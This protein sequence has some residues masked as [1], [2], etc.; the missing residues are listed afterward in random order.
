LI[1]IVKGVNSMTVNEEL[2]AYG[3]KRSNNFELDDV[4]DVDI[5]IFVYLLD[6]MVARIQ[7]GNRFFVDTNSEGISAAIIVERKRVIM[8]R[9]L[10]NT[11]TRDAVSASVFYGGMDFGHTCPGWQDILD[12]GIVGLRERA[13]RYGKRANNSAEQMRFYKNVV[14][15][16]DAALRYM[17]RA[18]QVADA[19]GNEEMSGG[20]RN[21]MHDRPKSLFEALQTLVVFYM[22]Q[23]TVENSMIRTFGRLDQLLYP[24]FKAETDREYAV[25]L[26]NDFVDTL[27]IMDPDAA[28]LP[29]ALGGYDADGNCAVN[30]LS[31]LLLDAYKKKPHPNVKL[32][33]MCSDVTPKDFLESALDG[34]RHG[35]NSICFF[36]DK[37]VMK[38]LLHIG[39]A[40]E[41]VRRYAILGCYEAAAYGEVACTSAGKINLPK[42]LELALFRGE[43]IVTGKSIGLQH[44]R[45]LDTFEDVFAAFE[46]QLRAACR[47]SI[48]MANHMESN[49]ARLHAAP[50]FSSSY[51]N[52]MER[53]GDIFNAHT[54]KYNNTSVCAI[55]LATCVD[56][57]VAIRKM[58]FEDKVV[59]IEQLKEILRSDWKDAE[60]LRQTVRNTYPKYGQGNA[61]A[62]A[63]A[64]RIVKILS[65]EIN[66]RP[67]T[68]GGVFRLGILSINWRW[69]M[70]E[71]TGASADGRHRGETLS[72]NTGASFGS[73]KYGT[74][75]HFISVSQIGNDWCPNGSICDVDLHISAI[76]GNDGLHAMRASLETFLEIGGFAAHYNVLDAEVLKKAK[77]NPALYPDLQVRLCGWN[78]RFASLSEKEKDE[79][80]AR[81][82]A[83]S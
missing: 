31:Y 83:A 47:G 1:C 42:S 81:F 80:I 41:D 18:A 77:E 3:K 24:F 69:E 71:K 4:S 51:E 20:I 13:V 17:D 2:F 38:S 66:N 12:L 62:D 61:E 22:F 19:A 7:E 55:G 37:T 21:L 14:R 34:V 28:N 74:T 57:L 35:N 65:E 9:W 78:V 15:V 73:T 44:E 11:G 79:F 36:S 64:A 6:H 58:V 56:S 50:F 72:L 32:H 53:G 67:N 59:T 16:Y 40:E 25:N 43:D 48:A 27:E 33:I 63:I 45:K 52:V 5:D 23:H 29:F 54:A 75:A 82:D 68:K 30:E 49:S 76:S 39:A 26:L 70:G 10:D 60:I 8:N 46:E